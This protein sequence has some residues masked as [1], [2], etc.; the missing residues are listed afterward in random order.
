MSTHDRMKTAALVLP[1]LAAAAFA[2]EPRSL[3]HA[4]DF[5]CETATAAGAGLGYRVGHAE[6]LAGPVPQPR[7]PARPPRDAGLSDRGGGDRRGGAADRGGRSDLPDLL[8][9]RPRQRVHLHHRARR[10]GAPGVEAGAGA[11]DLRGAVVAAL[12]ATGAATL[13]GA[14]CVRVEGLGLAFIDPS[15][16]IIASRCK[17]SSK[18]AA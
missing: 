15:Q 14:R 1:L 3:Q 7:A 13:C 17:N 11:A 8:P 6:P 16:T 18:P 2:G 9:E 10:A 4:A 5:T 12:R